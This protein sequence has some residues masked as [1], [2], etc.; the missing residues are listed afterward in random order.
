MADC[1]YYIDVNGKKV[2]LTEDELIAHLS[3]PDETGVSPFDQFVKDK[4]LDLSQIK[5]P[6]A[7][8][9]RRPKKEVSRAI[10]AGQDITKGG[11]RVRPSQ[12]GPRAAEETKSNEEVVKMRSLY[13][14]LINRSTGLSEMQKSILESDPNALY[15]TLPVAKVREFALSLIK[16]LGVEEAVKE[17]SNLYN[18]MQ[19]VERTMILGGA[20]DYYSKL[21][22][23]QQ[24]VGNEKAV[25]DAAQKELDANEKLKE[26]TSKL[27][28]LG[29]DYGRAINIF[30]EIYKLSNIALVQKL[31]KNIEEINEIRSKEALTQVK[32]ISSVLK[33]NKSDIQQAANDITEAQLEIESSDETKASKLS[34]EVARLKKE[35]L[36]RDNAQKATKKNP[37]KIQRITNDTEYDKRLKD[38]M[39]RTRSIAS[40]DDLV[41]LTYFGLY[42]IE[43][44]ITKFSDW[45]NVMSRKFKGFSK[46]LKNVYASVREKSIENGADKSLFSTDDEATSFMSELQKESDAKKIVAASKKAAIAEIKKQEKNDPEK[47]R[48]LAPRLAAERIRKDAESNLNMPSTAEEQDYLKKMV[49][50]INQKAKEY[51][52]DKKQNIKNVNDILSFAIANNKTDYAIWE[53]TQAELED[54]IDNNENLTEERK[55]EIKEFLDDYMNSIF[56]T[57]L[58]KNQISDV[59]REKLIDAGFYKEKIINNKSVKSIDW[60]KV[61]GNASNIAE[62]KERI[63]KSILDLGFTIDQAKPE[64]NAILDQFDSKIADIKTKEVNKIINKGV[65]NKVKSA[66]GSKVPKTKI[67]RLIELNNKGILNDEKIKEGLAKELGL[68]TLSKEDIAEMRELSTIIDNPDIPYFMKR[69]FEERLQYIMDTKGGNIDFLENREAVMA[70]KLS[71]A[72]NQI[73]NSTGFARPVSTLFTVAAKTG[74]PFMAAKVFGKEFANSIADAITILNGRVS[75]GSSFADLTKVTEGEARVRYLE[76]GKGKFL[77]GKFLGKPVY[78]Q[79]GGKKVDLNPLNAAYSKVKYIQRLLEAVDTLSSATVSGLTQ[80]WQINKQINKFYPELSSKEKAQKVYEL[81]YSLDREAELG[82]AIESLKA[83]G[84]SNPTT[85]EIN[86]AINERVERARNDEMAKEFY[87]TIDSLKPMAEK[88]LKLDGNANPT[89]EEIQN[90]AYRMIGGTEPLDVVAR[91]ERQAGRETGKV[92][93]VGITSI[94]LMPM[95]AIQSYINK[96]VK[97]SKSKVGTSIANAGDIAFTQTFPFVHSIG[98]WTEMQLEL[99]PYGAVKG[100]GYKGFA[101]LTTQKPDAKISNEEYNELG[102]DYIIRSVLGTAYTASLMYAISLVKNLADDDEEAKDAIFGVAKAEKY[103]QERVQSVGKPKE[104]V[105]I[106]G[107]FIPLDLLGNEGRVLGMYADYLTLKNKTPEME[108]RSKIYIGALAVI[109]SAIDASWT[110]NASKYGGM[111]SAMFKGKEEKYEPQLGK[112]AGGILGSQIPFNRFQTEMATLLNP[113]SKQSTD[114]GTNVLNQMSIT[115]AFTSGKPSFDYRGRNYDYGEI[116]ANSADGVVKM[117]SKGKYG[118]EI[119]A[120]LSEI[121]FGATDAFQKPKE[122]E[123]YKFAIV[124]PDGTQRAMTSEEYYNFRLKTAQKFN[125]SISADYQFIKEEEIEDNPE[126]TVNLKREIAASKLQNAKLE[127]FSEIQEATGFSDPYLLKQMAKEKKKI[128]EKKEKIKKYYKE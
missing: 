109:N 79:L 72:Y 6:Y 120:F 60:A 81:M 11:E 55:E 22:N 67:S 94:I 31:E 125:A 49:K 37:L 19:P 9:V 29:T 5:E 76:Q 7:L 77:G 113:K 16:G 20:M 3:E 32:K 39:Q 44:G 38:F 83:A 28:Q 90:E 128:A 46:D 58:T 71:S 56:D 96:Q 24:K 115:K 52:A 33:E 61:V 59:I 93:T 70:N 86:R 116:F 8:Q 65:L 108:D 68:I 73:Q 126:E 27:G 103:A 13:K 123:G 63:T 87:K 66:L 88:K 42:H 119:D 124:N 10:G 92:T 89:A 100:L 105:K 34:E 4:T 82:K 104:T 45:Y 122:I 35:I 36:E 101:K 111:F 64:I 117:F 25:I 85:Y 12:Q 30:K 102:D 47:A 91:G 62:A 110:S 78:A 51:Y 80:F 112:I 53:K 18:G 69:Q 15:T 106:G 41:D 48:A 84:V 14:Q 43:N 75:R 74:K 97:T 118:D 17:A 21:A 1:L 26:V 127:A 107:R 40:K 114:F 57:F 2:G 98:R 23:E 50:M 95:D 99:T 121:N 54:V